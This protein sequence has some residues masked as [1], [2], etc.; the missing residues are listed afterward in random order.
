M[1]C[2]IDLCKEDVLEKYGVTLLGTPIQ[3]IMNTEDRE[4]FNSEILKI[5]EKV[6][7][8]RS[9]TTIEEAELAAEKVI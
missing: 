7:P 3:S 9:A 4:R 8:S 2:A 6:S 5:G 1:N